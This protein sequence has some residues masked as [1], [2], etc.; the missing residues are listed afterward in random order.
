VTAREDRSFIFHVLQE[1]DA[2]ASHNAQLNVLT[3]L[4][5]VYISACLDV[6]VSFLLS[7]SL[8]FFLRR[9]TISNNARQREARTRDIHMC[10]KIGRR[11]RRRRR[12]RRLWL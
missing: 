2:L 6:F 5:C 9:S 1:N 10:V 3:R 11:Q 4:V 8:S 7:L 12:R